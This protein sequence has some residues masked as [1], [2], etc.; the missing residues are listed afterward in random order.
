M[1]V[2]KAALDEVTPVVAAMIQRSKSVQEA[3]RKFKPEAEMRRAK[4]ADERYDRLDRSTTP[5]LIE[6]LRDAADDH[7]LALV[8]AVLRVFSERADRAKYVE[9][10]AEAFS[11]VVFPQAA[12][13]KKISGEVLS[14]SKLGEERFSFVHSGR[15]NPI[16]KLNAVRMAR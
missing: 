4:S 7:D 9:A 5:E 6:Y 10:F 15:S 13:Y 8:G 3:A 1:A 14:L 16:A 12:A 11:R 2:R